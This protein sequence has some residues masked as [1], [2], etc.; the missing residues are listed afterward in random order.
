[1]TNEKIMK[2]SVGLMPYQD[3][4]A[5]GATCGHVRPAR[6]WCRICVDPE[7][8]RRPR[9]FRGSSVRLAVVLTARCGMCAGRGPNEAHLRAPGWGNRSRVSRDWCS[10]H[11]PLR[12]S[13]SVK[14]TI[15]CPW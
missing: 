7:V 4:I 2:F 1:M 9:P 14:Q 6:S 8:V 11:G 5:H 15:Q 10:C 12:S 3:T 13:G